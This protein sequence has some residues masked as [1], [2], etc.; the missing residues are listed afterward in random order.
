MLHSV[1][2]TVH[3]GQIQ[4]CEDVNLPEG[5]KLLV[6]VL[7]DDEDDFW[8]AASQSSLAAVWDNS[9]DDTYAQLLEG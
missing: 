5:A 2:A 3:A 6:T 8:L 1:L 9:E 4:L 7:P